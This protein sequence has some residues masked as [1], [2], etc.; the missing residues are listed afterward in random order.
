M[1][2]PT[3]CVVLGADMCHSRA[4][5]SP[6]TASCRAAAGLLVKRQPRNE[7]R[8][9]RPGG[10]V[11]VGLPQ[12]EPFWQRAHRG[13]GALVRDGAL[14]GAA[15]EVKGPCRVSTRCCVGPT[16]RGTCRCSS[17]MTTRK[18]PDPPSRCFMSTS[19]AGPVPCPRGRRGFC[20]LSL[21]SALRTPTS[22]PRQRITD[23]P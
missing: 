17:A 7:V 14:R 18:S 5:D 3:T 20:S 15:A 21:A 11:G 12:R 13:G 9:F 22:G 16:R 4:K 23:H 6:R 8:K 10:V 2:A 19:T 1:D